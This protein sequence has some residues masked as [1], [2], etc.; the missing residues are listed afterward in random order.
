[1]FSCYYLVP[2]G[3]GG[4]SGSHSP[5]L[6]LLPQPHLRSSGVRFVY[7]HSTWIPHMRS[8]QEGSYLTPRQYSYD[9]RGAQAVMRAVGSR[10][11]YRRNSCVPVVHLL[12]GP[13]PNRP[14]TT[15]GSYPGV[16]GL[17]SLDFVKR[18]RILGSAVRS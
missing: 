10:C 17:L 8:S 4:D 12:C 15:T 6:E 2:S 9:R 16:W 14:W 3:G 13:V 11:K 1:M 5:L 7:G 18:G